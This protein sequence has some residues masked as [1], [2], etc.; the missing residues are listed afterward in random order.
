MLK[1]KPCSWYSLMVSGNF[2]YCQKHW[3]KQI[4]VSSWVGRIMDLLFTRF[5][6]MLWL[7]HFSMIVFTIVS[8]KPIFRM[9]HSL[10]YDWKHYLLLFLL[11][12]AI[13]AGD[14]D[15]HRI[16][17]WMMVFVEPPIFLQLWSEVKFCCGYSNKK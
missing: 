2:R 15:Y 3:N 10:F 5:L 16:D 17:Q 12:G 13:K 8:P 14:E 7:I 4:I 11:G 1:A 9:Q 6:P